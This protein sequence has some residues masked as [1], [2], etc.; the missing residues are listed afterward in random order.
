M[1]KPEPLT[2]T[3]TPTS[4]GLVLITLFVGTGRHRHLVSR[5]VHVVDLDEG[6]PT[7]AKM[8]LAAAEACARSLR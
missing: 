4:N 5:P 6:W 1:S 8:I 2:L 3:I 7:A